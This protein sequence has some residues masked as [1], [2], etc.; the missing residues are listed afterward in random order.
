MTTAFDP[1]ELGGRPL[2]NRIAMAPMTR[3]R[4]YGAAFIH[5]GPGDFVEPRELSE[6]EIARTVADFAAAARNAIVA[7]FDGV[8]VHGANGYLIHQFL[9]P[10]V[11]QRTD[12]W[13]G[14][15]AGRIR[16]GVQVAAAVAE[17]I[18]GHRTGFRISL[19]NPLND[20]AETDP[21]DAEQTYATLV[22]RLAPLDLAYLHMLEGPDR[23]LTRHLRRP[24]R[25]QQALNTCWS[26]PS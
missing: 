26:C 15:V 20:I 25:R 1:I 2:A 14:S 19:G 18:G 22:A 7:G 17:A 12:G 6:Q 8:E 23:D 9:A 5:D 13:G 11:N 21:A 10:N 24:R 3:S 4:A 16:F